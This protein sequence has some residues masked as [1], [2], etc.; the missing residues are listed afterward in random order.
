MEESI[1]HP[2]FK[3]LV[4]EKTTEDQIL[5]EIKKE[6]KDLE[7]ILNTTLNITEQKIHTMK[8]LQISKEET[9]IEKDPHQ[10]GE[11]TT[12]KNSSPTNT[13][14]A[15]TKYFCSVTKFWFCQSM[16]KGKTR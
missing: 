9:T 15:R 10:E 13:S 3:L 5:N 16:W 1:N 2:R 14:T 8:S 6:L 11:H 12:D 7:M 4:R